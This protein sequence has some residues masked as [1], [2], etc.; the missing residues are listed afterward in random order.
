MKRFIKLAIIQ[1][2]VVIFDGTDEMAN[3]LNLKQDKKGWYAYK[4][5]YMGQKSD[6]YH[7]KENDMLCWFS[8]QYNPPSWYYIPK[9][10][11]RG[12]AMNFTREILVPEDEYRNIS[13]YVLPG[14]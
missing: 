4:K 11:Y 10:K 6:K 14:S 12:P 1:Y 7:L 2:D 13:R 9:R 3:E 8:D 5:V